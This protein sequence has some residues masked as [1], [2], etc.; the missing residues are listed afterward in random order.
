[1]DPFIYE[2]NP[3]VK[4]PRHTKGLLFQVVVILTILWA[5]ATLPSLAFRKR[6]RVSLGYP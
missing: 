1:M 3:K 5:L 2:G 6:T 4:V